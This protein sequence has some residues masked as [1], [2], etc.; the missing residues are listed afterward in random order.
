MPAH[1]GLLVEGPVLISGVFHVAAHSLL[2]ASG[3]MARISLRI[4]SRLATADLSIW[5]LRHTVRRSP[6]VRR[7]SFQAVSLLAM[8]FDIAIP[9]KETGLRPQI[10]ASA[11]L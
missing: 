5:I 9:A 11:E 10:W 3:A 1:G 2:S 4:P 8:P 7:L 6:C